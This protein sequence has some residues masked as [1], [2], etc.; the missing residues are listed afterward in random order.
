MRLQMT[1]LEY[2]ERRRLYDRVQK[3]VSENLPIVCLA[4]P[5]LLVAA[6]RRLGNFH[7]AVLRSYALWNADVLYFLE[8]TTGQ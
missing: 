1:T 4:S 6:T 7:P 8:R 5:H 2:P 3:L